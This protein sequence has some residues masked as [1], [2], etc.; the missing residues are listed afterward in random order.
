MKAC[1]VTGCENVAT[2]LVTT[3]ANLPSLGGEVEI[4]LELCHEHADNVF[5]QV[6]PAV[7]LPE[8]Q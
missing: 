7:S 8:P 5:R 2:R 4:P 6:L 3:T 1:A